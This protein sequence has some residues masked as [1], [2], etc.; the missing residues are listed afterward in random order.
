M[1]NYV[2][3]DSRTFRYYGGNIKVTGDGRFFVPL[4]IALKFRL[5]SDTSGSIINK[6]G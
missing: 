6:V 4:H 3:V 1:S 5:T 2:E